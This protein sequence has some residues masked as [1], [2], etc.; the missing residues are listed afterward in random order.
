MPVRSFPG[1]NFIESLAMLP[2]NKEGD[3]FFFDYQQ[4]AEGNIFAAGCLVNSKPARFKKIGGG[5]AD[6]LARWQMIVKELE[7]AEVQLSELLKRSVGIEAISVDR[8]DADSVICKALFDSAVI[9]YAKCFNSGEGR[10]VKLESRDVF[11]C[12]M[13]KKFAMHHAEIKQI[14]DTYIAHAGVTKFENAACFAVV[15]PSPRKGLSEK[16]AVMSAH[17]RLPRRC[18]ME[19]TLCLITFVKSK[20]ET[21]LQSRINT[22]TQK[23]IKNPTEYELEG[24]YGD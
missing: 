1:P 3:E 17:F 8:R 9:S 21:Q 23:V 15:D 10:R 20:V 12:E 2:I 5:E 19:Q 7:F 24:F 11:S 16:C 13:G 14:R 4:D 6:Q 18:H 22:F